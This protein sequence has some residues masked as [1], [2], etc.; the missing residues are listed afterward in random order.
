MK[1]SRLARDLDRH[2]GAAAPEERDA[3]TEG[4]HVLGDMAERAEGMGVPTPMLRLAR[5]NVAS[6][7][8][9]LLVSLSLVLSFAMMNLPQFLREAVITDSLYP[10]LIVEEFRA[11]PAMA[12]ALTLPR[13]PSFV[14]DLL[15]TVA[16]DLLTGSWRL[17]LWAYGFA[18]V[19][20]LVALGGWAAADSFACGLRNA[21]LALAVVLVATLLPGVL[22]HIAA[23]PTTPSIGLA[24]LPSK[25]AC[26]FNLSFMLFIPVWQSGAFIAGLA[27]LLMMWWGA[28]AP[29]PSRLSLLLAV[30]ALS[31]CSNKIVI[32]HAVL[33][34][35]IAFTEAV[36]RRRLAIQPVVLAVGT[37]AAGTAIG[38]V[39]A[40]W[41]GTAPLPAT[42]FSAAI[43][44][45]PLLLAHLG[46]QPAVIA[47]L[48]AALPLGAVSLCAVASS[49]AL[50]G[51]GGAA[52]RFFLIAS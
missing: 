3:S 35:A 22:Q 9:T 11:D 15:I 16:V 26:P 5:C 46:E 19:L 38:V 48:V 12:R 21:T 34:G 24:L 10:A 2:P 51:E 13:V 31:V 37:A 32:F 43:A 49:R 30:A 41:A 50:A 14:P 25:G 52:L 40:E 18:A 23:C 8:V 44:N 1:R 47:M 7:D 33:P 6:R 27:V 36:V 45:F 20:L 42:K 4:E 29:R 17:G 39:L 28:A